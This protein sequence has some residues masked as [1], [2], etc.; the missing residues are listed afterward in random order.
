MQ[1]VSSSPSMSR[2]GALC[3]SSTAPASRPSPANRFA[4][5]SIPASPDRG[6]SPASPDRDAS[7]ASPASPDRDA[8]PASL[9]QDAV[10]RTVAAYFGFAALKAG[11]R[12]VIEHLLATGDG[13]GD[14]VCKFPTG[15]GKSLCYC[16]PVLNTH[17]FALVVSPLC[18][19]IQD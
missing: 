16:V 7:P 17:R 4:I 10:E 12:E 5:E 2:E 14:V 15:I 11:Q 6:G 19:L 18:S 3:G 1:A 13:G 9:E 8:S